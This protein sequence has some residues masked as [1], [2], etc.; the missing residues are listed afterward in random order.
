VLPKKFFFKKDIEISLPSR[1]LAAGE[2]M[3]IRLGEGEK[4]E[5]D[6]KDADLD[7]GFKQCPLHHPC[8]LPENLMKKVLV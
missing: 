8:P 1:G 7:T 4:P 6:F 5:W 2:G 3:R